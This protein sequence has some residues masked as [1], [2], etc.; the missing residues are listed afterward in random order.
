M[1]I[2]NSEN[3]STVCCN[4]TKAVCSCS[5]VLSGGSNERIALTS[6]LSGILKSQSYL[7]K[8]NYYLCKLIFYSSVCPPPVCA[9]DWVVTFELI[10]LNLTS[11]LCFT[12][13]DNLCNV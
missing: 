12:N 10:N 5:D 9:P 3:A 4:A 1:L 13:V 7:V 2:G 11:F 6:G 8:V